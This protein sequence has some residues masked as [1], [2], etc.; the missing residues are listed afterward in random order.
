MVNEQNRMMGNPSCLCELV[1]DIVLPDIQASLLM[2]LNIPD[3][4]T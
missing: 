4:N 3:A 1:T 2:S